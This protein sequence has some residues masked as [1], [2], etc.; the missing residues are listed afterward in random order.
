[1]ASY[2]TP[3]SRCS[4]SL[5]AIAGVDQVRVAVDE[6]G[7]DPAALAVDDFERIELPGASAAG[8]A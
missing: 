7:R 8:P 3:F 4:N 2:E 5:G 6:A 1:M